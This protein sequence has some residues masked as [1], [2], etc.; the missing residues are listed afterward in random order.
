MKITL[1]SLF[2]STLFLSC[3]K[4]PESEKVHY[5]VVD[6]KYFLIQNTLNFTVISR[7][8]EFRDTVNIIS[9]E[10]M[11]YRNLYFLG[12]KINYITNE[13]IDYKKIGICIRFSNITI[14]SDTAKVMFDYPLDGS[15]VFIRSDSLIWKPI[16]WELIWD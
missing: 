13:Q 16:S 12:K 5:G 6:D 11:T 10:A 14:S 15:I 4:K 8:F 7:Y 2:L 9:N 1:I 3:D